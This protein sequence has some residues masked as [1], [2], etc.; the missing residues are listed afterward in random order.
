MGFSADY[1]E[2]N[3]AAISLMF[4]V[5]DDA[6]YHNVCSYKHMYLSAEVEEHD[7]G[8]LVLYAIT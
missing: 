6:T 4:P 5:G 1:S 2:K 8:R 7:L 3:M